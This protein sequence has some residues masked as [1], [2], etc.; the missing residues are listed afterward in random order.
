MPEKQQLAADKG[1]TYPSDSIDTNEAAKRVDETEE[2]LRKALQGGEL[3]EN[4]TRVLKSRLSEFQKAIAAWKPRFDFD[5]WD[6]AKENFEQ[7]WPEIR[8][9]LYLAVEYELYIPVKEMFFDVRH[10]LQIT[11]YLKERIYIATWL[12]HEAKKRGDDGTA[13]LATSSLVWSYTS[14]GQHQNLNK[15]YEF[16]TLL[17]PCI[18]ALGDPF[19]DNR[20]RLELIKEIGEPLYLELIMDIHEGGVRLAVRQERFE[21]VQCYIARA[22]KEISILSQ[23]NILTKRLKERFDLCFCYHEGVA[24]YL[25]N[26]YAKANELFDEVI[27]RATPIGWTRAIKGAKSWL[28]TLA[29]V[30]EDYDTCNSILA[31][32]IEKDVV[33]SDKRDGICRLLKAQ[34]LIN[35]NSK[36]LAD[37]TSGLKIV[38]ALERF[39]GPTFN[40]NSKSIEKLSKIF[41]LSLF[42]A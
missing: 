27:Y 20:Y 38:Q 3:Y 34:M 12:M 19:K 21:D 35:Q 10:L 41:S 24:A 22:G 36:V 16:W 5:L 32:I 15:A 28:A 18:T 33:P 7:L 39:T 25:Q 31:E 30:G 9:S 13:Y 37:A 8:D 11:G 23:K 2:Y 42:I 14:A 17:T 26:D 6:K 40:Q 1:N 29:M 4:N